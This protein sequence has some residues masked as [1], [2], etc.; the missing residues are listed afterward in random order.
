MVMN[1]KEA[2]KQGKLEAFI[3]ERSEQTGDAPK[4]DAAISSMAQG[5]SKEA[6]EA[7]PKDSHE[8]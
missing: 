4:F 2:L 5:K 7:S 1:L 8:S 6:Q 3:K